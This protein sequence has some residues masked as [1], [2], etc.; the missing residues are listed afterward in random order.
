MQNIETLKKDTFFRKKE[1]AKK[2]F[3]LNGYC[4]LNK[5]YEATNWDDASD[6]IYIKK[7]KKVFTNFDF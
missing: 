5:A 7:G 1:G 6:F 2:T 4:R 3:I